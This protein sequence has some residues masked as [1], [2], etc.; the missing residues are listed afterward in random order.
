MFR[1]TD[2]H[3]ALSTEPLNKKQRSANIYIKYGIHKTY[4]ICLK[5]CKIDK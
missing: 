5:L 1:P 4:E 3:Q 2:H